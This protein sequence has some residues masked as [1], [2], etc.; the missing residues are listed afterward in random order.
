MRPVKAPVARVF[1]PPAP[2]SPTA[3][4]PQGLAAAKGAALLGCCAFCS[5]PVPPPLYVRGVQRYLCRS[6]QCLRAYQRLAA[7]DRTARAGACRPTLSFAE[8]FWARVDDA[9]PI[10]PHDG[11]QC[12][13]WMGPVKQDGYGQVF[14]RP[15]KA[16]TAHRIAWMLCNGDPGQL[17]VLHRCDN[18]RCVRAD[19]DSAKSHLFL[20]TAA[21]NSKDMIVKGRA[22]DCRVLGEKHGNA[23]LTTSLVVEARRL[24][25][26]GLTYDQLALYFGVKKSTIANA[27]RGVNWRW[28]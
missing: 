17:F 13:L 15:P 8:R 20:G 27:V 21:D 19:T 2:A 25:S 11:S 24:K 23:V 28:L 16:S 4:H 14:T 9:G 7:R 3:M 12:W 18:P 26:T 1:T 6:A 22:G 5:T 10:S